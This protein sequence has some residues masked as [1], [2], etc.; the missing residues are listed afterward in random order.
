ML[1]KY[2]VLII[3]GI[4]HFNWP[5]TLKKKKSYNILIQQGTESLFLYSVCILNRLL[6]KQVKSKPNLC[7]HGHVIL[8]QEDVSTFEIKAVVILP[9]IPSV[10]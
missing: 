4:H 1:K 7:M 8:V 5:Q 2:A 10:I 6:L 9:E 3:K